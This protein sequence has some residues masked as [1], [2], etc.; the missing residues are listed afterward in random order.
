[1][2]L[3]MHPSRY[4]EAKCTER[5]SPIKCATYIVLSPH[6]LHIRHT[7][8][9]TTV[10]TIIWSYF[11]ALLKAT[12]FGNAIAT[13]YALLNT[14]LCEHRIIIISKC[15]LLLTQKRIY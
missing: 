6:L 2:Y 1:M 7:I 15:S 9:S 4:S 10:L 8:L 11:K 5:V 3:Y 12:T 14:S 13:M